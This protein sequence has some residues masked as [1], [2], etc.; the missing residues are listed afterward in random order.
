MKVR[1]PTSYFRYYFR[2]SDFSPLGSTRA[3]LSFHFT[4]HL[5]FFLEDLNV[6][7]NVVQPNCPNAAMVGGF[8]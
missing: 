2:F 3:N 1:L 8:G 6:L 5:S 7:Y 4:Q